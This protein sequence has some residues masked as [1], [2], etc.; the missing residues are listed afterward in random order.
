MCFEELV[1]LDLETAAFSGGLRDPGG[2]EK[3]TTTRQLLQ[4]CVYSETV[5]NPVKIKIVLLWDSD[6]P[7]HLENKITQ[8]STT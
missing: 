8:G 7:L 2:G 4:W 6:A 3:K 1:C 5:T